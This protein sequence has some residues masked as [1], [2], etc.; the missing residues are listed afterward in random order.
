MLVARAICCQF[1]QTFVVH[2]QEIRC[3]DPA[4]VRRTLQSVHA[5]CGGT[6]FSR[7][8]RRPHVGAARRS[9]HRAQRF[10]EDPRAGRNSQHQSADR[11]PQQ[12]HGRLNHATLFWI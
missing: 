9:V 6:Q 8:D 11:N 10:A 12:G 4:S 1:Q 2:L 5:E 7:E 3:N